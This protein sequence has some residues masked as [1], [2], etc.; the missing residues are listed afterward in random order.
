MKFL[1]RPNNSGT[2]IQLQ[3]KRRNSYVARKSYK[4]EFGKTKYY[5]IGYYATRKEALTALEDFNAKNRGIEPTTVAKQNIT[6]SQTF[7]QL[8]DKFLRTKQE[9]STYAV[10]V[11][12]SNHFEAINKVDIMQLRAIQIQAC[13]DSCNFKSAQSYVNMKTLV[14]EV[15]KQALREEIDVKNLSDLIVIPDVKKKEAIHKVFTREE[16]AELWKDP[17]QNYVWLCLIYTGL[18]IGELLQYYNGDTEIDFTND[19]ISV[20]KSKTSAGVRQVPI[21]SKIKPVL[22]YFTQCEAVPS[23]TVRYNCKKIGHLPH[24]CRHTCVSLLVELGVEQLIVQKLVGHTSNSVTG[25]VYTHLN[26]DI[27]RIEM[28][29]LSAI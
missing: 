20:N 7:E 13:F 18:R 27:L 24:D 21:C 22:Q 9:K 29:K 12:A 23:R 16:I 5:A 1:R 15:Y 6:K 14:N 25:N 4:D 3:G 17:K 2:V 19:V 28:E 26:V 8:A 11:Q 10:Y